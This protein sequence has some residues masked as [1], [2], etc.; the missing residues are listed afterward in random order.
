[1]N[2][3]IF[4]ILQCL[5]GEEVKE[6]INSTQ[7]SCEKSRQGEFRYN[8]HY[9]MTYVELVDLLRKFH[10]VIACNDFDLRLAVW[11]KKCYHN[12]KFSII[13]IM[14]IMGSIM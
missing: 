7:S 5:N 9:W 6:Y 10:Y 12:A 13:S 11:E 2:V 4:D 1:M 8:E 3:S 14:S